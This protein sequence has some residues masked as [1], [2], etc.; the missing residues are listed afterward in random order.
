VTRE[1]KGH[2]TDRPHSVLVASDDVAYTREHLGLTI[3]EPRLTV[4]AGR[5][6]RKFRYFG[7]AFSRLPQEFQ[8]SISER[9]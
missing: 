9:E 4:Q 6:T 1:G 7:G 5:I 8:A 2:F 3:D